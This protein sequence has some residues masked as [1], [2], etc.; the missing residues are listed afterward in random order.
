[1]VMWARA[2][3][4]AAIVVA[5]VAAAPPLSAVS[6]AS[7]EA[8]PTGPTVAADRPPIEPIGRRWS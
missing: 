5:A 1:M 6:A 8:R 3:A 4:L 2:L 7:L